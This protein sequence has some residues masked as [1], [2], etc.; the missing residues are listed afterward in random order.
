MTPEE[1]QLLLKDLCDRLPY[2]PYIKTKRYSIPI[3]LTYISLDHVPEIKPYLRPMSSI[4]KEE[5]KKL[6]S[7]S[8]PN[9]FTKCVDVIDYLY[10]IHVDVHGLLEKN[11]ALPATPEMYQNE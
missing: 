2:R 1:K 6:Y 7:F 9:G 4:T 11:L 8:E 10:S 3:E 5:E